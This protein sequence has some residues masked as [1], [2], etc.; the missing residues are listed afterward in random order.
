MSCALV[1]RCESGSSLS[2][3]IRCLRKD[4]VPLAGGLSRAYKRQP[5]LATAAATAPPA[6][7]HNRHA[8]FT[9]LTPRSVLRAQ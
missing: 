8:K 6:L 4:D 5:H 1:I 9:G 3:H 7:S 2:G